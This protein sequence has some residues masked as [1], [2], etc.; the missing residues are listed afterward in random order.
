MNRYPAAFSNALIKNIETAK[1]GDDLAIPIMAYRI[2]YLMVSLIRPDTEEF[3]EVEFSV[4]DFKEYF[5]IKSW[6]GNQQDALEYAISMLR[7]AKYMVGDDEITWLDLESDVDDDLIHL[8]LHDSLTPYLL[9]L[10]GNFTKIHY[11]NIK[12]LKSKYAFRLYE[13]LSSMKGIGK[14]KVYLKTAYKT[15]GDE[16]YTT[17]SE[18]TAHVIDPA[19][20]EINKYTDLTVSYRFEKQFGVPEQIIFEIVG[21]KGFGKISLGKTIAKTPKVSTSKFVKLDS[22]TDDPDLTP[23]TSAELKEII[24]NDE[25]KKIIDCEQLEDCDDLPF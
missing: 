22:E 4:N 13:L 12:N 11:D 2:K 3:E 9:G 15:I 23:I 6:G 8:R 14:Y 7:G 25:I 10:K 5:E 20:E 19:I 17:K 18:F 24:N 21:S 16:N 1:L